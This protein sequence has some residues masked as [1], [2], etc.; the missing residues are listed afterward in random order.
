MVKRTVAAAV[1]IVALA[2]ASTASAQENATLLLRSGERV[3]GQLVDMGGSDFTM[4]VNGQERRIP[5]SDVT[6]ID[7]VGGAS[8]IPD[9]EVA[10]IQSGSH[11]VITRSSG[12]QVG[13][14]FD[15]SG[16]S[17]LKLTFRTA[18]GER[19]VASNEIGRIFLDRPSTGVVATT[20]TTAPAPASAP[21]TTT[22]PAAT[23]VTPPPGAITVPGNVA[24]TS[25]GVRVRQGDRVAFNAVGTIG[26][27]ADANDTSGPDGAGS[28]RMAPSA[29]IPNVA[30]GAL[31]FRIDTGPQSTLGSNTQPVTMPSNGTL[32][33]CIN[34]D[35]VG[36]NT[37]QFYVTVTP[38]TR[39]R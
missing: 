5:I 16:T 37:G 20:G 23:T 7:F 18:S 14:L 35:H 33:V 15:I 27:S 6:V 3:T 21:A 39:R 26:L 2:C 9:T 11:L 13:T 25:T 28:G 31:T 36:D 4:T 1:F 19:S 38:Q 10:G 22:A 34:D 29:P 12:S 30:V 32:F 24:C 8:G 17:P